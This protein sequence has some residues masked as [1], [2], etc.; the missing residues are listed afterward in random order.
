ML[1]IGKIVFGVVS[2]VMMYNMLKID[3]PPFLESVKNNNNVIKI[4]SFYYVY[5][6][7]QNIPISI[8][9]VLI[10]EL[11]RTYQNEVMDMIK[12]HKDNIINEGNKISNRIKSKKGIENFTNIFFK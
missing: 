10:I 6:L 11:S 3:L 12:K 9:S 8:L 5:D 4:F 1:E 7:T 2:L